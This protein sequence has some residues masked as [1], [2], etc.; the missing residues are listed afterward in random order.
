MTIGIVGLLTAL[1]GMCVSQL[2]IFQILE[3]LKRDGV[4]VESSYFLASV[5]QWRRYRP[6]VAHRNRGLPRFWRCD[7]VAG[8]GVALGGSAC[9][10]VYGFRP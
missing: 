4:P 1:A 10:E 3:E 7:R 9:V 6:R 5:A 8:L 2:A